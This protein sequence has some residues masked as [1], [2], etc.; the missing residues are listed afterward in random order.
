MANYVGR[1]TDAMD[2]VEIE[3]GGK[4]RYGRAVRH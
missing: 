4:S 3:I 2:G 1:R